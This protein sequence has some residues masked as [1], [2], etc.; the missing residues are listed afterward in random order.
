MK[1]TSA[2]LAPLLFWDQYLKCTVEKD[3]GLESRGLPAAPVPISEA[4]S[5]HEV[6]ALGKL[7]KPDSQAG[8]GEGPVS[9]TTRW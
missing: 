4:L 8:G 1:P 9:M 5:L 3:R 7:H 2:W 6:V